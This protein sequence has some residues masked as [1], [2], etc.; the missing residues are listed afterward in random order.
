MSLS[1]IHIYTH[2]CT[3]MEHDG[4]SKRTCIPFILTNDKLTSVDQYVG[5]I[6]HTCT[7][8]RVHVYTVYERGSNE[9]TYKSR[10]LII[11]SLKKGMISF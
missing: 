3:L 2:Y 11:H 5:E 8:M 6:L 10:L 9:R 4:M 7:C 1:I